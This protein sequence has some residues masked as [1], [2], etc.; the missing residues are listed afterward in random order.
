MDILANALGIIAIG[1]AIW[2]LSEIKAPLGS[3]VVTT[4]SVD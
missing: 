1:L 3:G 4:N 2:H